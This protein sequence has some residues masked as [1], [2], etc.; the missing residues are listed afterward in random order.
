MVCNFNVYKYYKFFF[1]I[2][3]VNMGPRTSPYLL[4]IIISPSITASSGASFL[5]TC[6]MSLLLFTISLIT[7]FFL[8]SF[9]HI[10]HI[11]VSAPNMISLYLIVVSLMIH[12]NFS[13]D[14]THQS[15]KFNSFSF[16]DDCVKVLIYFFITLGQVTKICFLYTC[17]VLRP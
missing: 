3:K 17:W 4:S 2:C 1:A 9:N 10:A 5:T 6:S 11:G 8:S 7:C 15:G 16:A 12:W 14:I 13:V